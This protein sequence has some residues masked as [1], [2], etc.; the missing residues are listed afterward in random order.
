M[1]PKGKPAAEVPY[2]FVNWYGVNS[3]RYFTDIYDE[4][5]TDVEGR[6]RFRT[7]KSQALAL[8]VMPPRPARARF[9][10]G[11]YQH[12]YSAARPDNPPT[13]WIPTDLG[14]MVLS[15]GVR[16]SGRLVDAQGQP[17][18]GQTIKAYPVIGGDQHLATT[19]AD[20]SFSLGPLRPANY[21][22]YGQGQD[23]FGSVDR[24]APALSK[25]IRVFRPVRVYL[26]E[27]AI[28][29]SLGAAQMPTV[30]VEVRF[31]DS[32]GRPAV[33]GPAKVWGVMPTEQGHGDPFGPHTAIGGGIVS[34]IND[35]E[36]KDTSERI[37]W[38]VQDR[39]DAD[40]RIIFLAPRGLLDAS[41]STYSFD[42]TIAY[43]T[44]LEAKGPL[45][46]WGGGGLGLLDR[47]RKITIVCY[48]APTVFVTI[49]T[50]DGEKPENLEVDASFVSNGG[51]YS[52]GFTPNPM[53]GTAAGASCPITNTRSSPD[54]G[55]MSPGPCPGS[56]FRK[57]ASPN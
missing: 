2:H 37:D 27:G 50:D 34:Q 33:G 26:K 24:D 32:Q 16:L 39:A 45:K 41:L 54:P 43:K 52:E 5:Q 22:I 42:E 13:T 44:R 14:R 46:H 12:F 25:P 6:I 48:R 36:P 49:K 53:A 19:E 56:I 18:A 29:R 11:P 15:R 9:P 31:V 57:E 23:G 35:P 8:Y 21:I 7:T 38:A 17:I 28:L 20:G 47:D 1:I 55:S 40:G 4:G 3:S 10:Y 51:S 30:R